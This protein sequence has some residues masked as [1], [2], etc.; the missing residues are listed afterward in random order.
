[1]SI[2]IIKSQ[3]QQ[4][5]RS[6]TSEV[7]AIRGGWG[8]G[9]TYSW[10]KFLFEEKQ[11][12][13]LKKYSYV[14]LFGLSSLDALKDSI[15][16][17]AIDT[18]LIGDGATVETFIDNTSSLLE[19]Y[20]RKFLDIVKESP[21]LKDFA[22]AIESLSFLSLNETLICIDD[23]ERRGKSLCL[24]D[25]L[26]L[27]SLLKEQKKCKVVLL[28]NDSKGEM[29]EYHTYREKVIDLELEFAPTAEESALIAF[30]NSEPEM[31][32]LGR[33]T[34]KLNINNIRILKKIERLVRL[35]KPL[36]KG[37]EQEIM[38]QA[39]QSLTLFTWCY[40]CSSVGAPPLDF[41]TSQRYRLKGI[42]V[43]QDETEEHKKW[44]SILNDYGYELTDDLDLV[45]V[46]AVRTGYFVEAYIKR[47]ASKKDELIKAAIS[48]CSFTKAWD[49]YSDSFDDN[50]DEVISTIYASFMANIENI[51]SL[52]L[53][54]TVIFFR[55][56]GEGAKATEMIDAFIEK[57]KEEKKIFDISRSNPFG[58]VWDAELIDKFN[59][60]Y[61]GVACAESAGQVLARIAGTDGWNEEDE[62]VLVGTSQE[63]YYELFKA[64]KGRTMS[65]YIKTCL[66]F[67]CLV[68][69]NDQQ[70]QISSRA[71]EALKKIAA[72]SELNRSRVRR[73][74]IGI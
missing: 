14:S 55:E 23:L 70:T 39:I 7:M 33:L 8:V 60:V 10:N 67:G 9:K 1:M 22:G 45:L 12:I 35:I 58:D 62:R 59:R 43:I 34:K 63:Q 42:G 72:E 30:D 18:K 54:A 4:F 74:G 36:L 50:L 61:E 32:S 53:N 56:L 13:A 26:G 46:D 65:L 44:K 27:V 41:V 2:E 73:F 3:I 25:V 29:V 51:S 19:S 47:E 21:R 49:F 38:E 48:A 69:A 28:L 6:P 31:I 64:V 40:Y 66:R 37:Y 15:F 52:N 5:V 16:A 71:T 20:G 17:Q 68:G 24:G 57:R 11:K